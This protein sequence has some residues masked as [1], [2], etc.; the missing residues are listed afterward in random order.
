MFAQLFE[1]SELTDDDCIELGKKV[2]KK[3]RLKIDRDLN[4]TN[5]TKPNL[6]LSNL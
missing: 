5:K 6:N 1:H 3:V 2:N 4:R